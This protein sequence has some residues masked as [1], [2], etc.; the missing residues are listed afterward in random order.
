MAVQEAP[1]TIVKAI[2]R[3]LRLPAELTDARL[4]VVARERQSNR[5]WPAYIVAARVA[6]A[7]HERGI[8]T[9][10]TG[11]EPV[12]TI[13]ALNEVARE[14]SDWG[15]AAAPDSPADRMRTRFA[16]YP[17]AHEVERAVAALA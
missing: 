11:P 10:A 6:V 4:A 14:C 9:W 1:P 2:S 16:G 3:G 8:G 7:E 13:W 12:I 15:E 5:R 17:E